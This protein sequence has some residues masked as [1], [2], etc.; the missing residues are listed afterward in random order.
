MRR[1][2]AGTGVPSPLETAVAFLGRQ[3]LD[4][5][6]A[7]PSQVQF[8]FRSSIKT[9]VT[10]IKFTLF[11]VSNVLWL[12]GFLAATPGHLQRSQPG[13]LCLSASASPA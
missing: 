2:R 4:V 3:Y 9:Q 1:E 7:S 8:S 13:T 6:H 10:Y 11:T 12:Y 5:E